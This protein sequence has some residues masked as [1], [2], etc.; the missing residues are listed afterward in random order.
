MGNET[1]HSRGA[2]V[3]VP[4]QALQ[5]LDRAPI[6]TDRD[7]P[8]NGVLVQCAAQ[9]LVAVNRGRYALASHGPDLFRSRYT[10]AAL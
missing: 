3:S 10:A 7:R 5:G 9:K 6:H 2:D 4:R 1:R 8:R